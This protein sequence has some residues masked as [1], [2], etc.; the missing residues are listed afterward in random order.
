MP[1]FDPTEINLAPRVRALQIITFALVMGC[2]FFAV[3]GLVIRGGAANPGLEV[4]VYLMAGFLLIDTVISS[5]WPMLTLPRQ[6]RQV[7]MGQ[8][9]P[10][11]GPFGTPTQPP[12][13]VQSEAGQLLAILQTQHI[14]RMALIEGGAFANGL[15]FIVTGSWISLVLLLVGAAM[16]A[17]QF[18]TAGRVSRWLENRLEEV[19]RLGAQGDF[20]DCG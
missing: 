4:I 18:P 8:W 20:P 13:W 5:L 9:R 19:E 1:T 17:V 7:A 6:L 10:P 11:S 15:A 12:A 14:V 3:L 2:V 16:I